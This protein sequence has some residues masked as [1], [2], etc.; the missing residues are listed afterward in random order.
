MTGRERVITALE[1]KE[2]DRV[3]RHDDFWDE[4]LDGYKEA[5]GL[6]GTATEREMGDYFGF[7]MVSFYLDNSMRFD[8]A[9]VDENEETITIRDR[10]G[11]TA[12]KHKG[13]PLLRFSNHVNTDYNKWQTIK[14]RYRFEKNDASRIDHTGFFLRTSQVPSWNKSKSLFREEY[15]KGKFLFVQGYGVFEGTWRH[16]GFENLMMDMLCEEAYTHE[17]FSSITELTIQTLDYAIS[18]GIKPDG[19]MLIDDLGS[20]RAALFSPETYR[21]MVFPYHKALGDFLHKKGIK[22]LLHSCGNIE[23]FI[24]YFIE[25]G[26]EAIQPLQANTSLNIGMLKKEYGRDI[27]FWGNISCTEIAK[28]YDAI[29]QEIASKLPLAMKGGGYIYH[30]DHSIPPNVPFEYYQHVI[31]ILNK[32]G[33]Y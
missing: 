12:L 20:T 33:V 2:P 23:V 26:I 32:Y 14:K 6:P 15:K 30:C 31:K 19:F 13:Q 4:I 22:Y 16:R 3:P 18:T 25:A 11:Y 10:C 7:D 17:M 8:A 24:P 28:G 27:T 21:K 9:V 5:L 29:Q 1:H